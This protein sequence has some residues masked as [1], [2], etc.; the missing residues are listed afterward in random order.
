[1][2]GRRPRPLHPVGVVPASLRSLVSDSQRARLL[3]RLF[4]CRFL[5]GVLVLTFILFRAIT[6]GQLYAPRPSTMHNPK[7]DSE[8]RL[9]LMTLE[10]KKSTFSGN[11]VYAQSIARSL[12]KRGNH[13]LVLSAKPTNKTIKLNN[14]E[15]SKQEMLQETELRMYEIDVEV[16]GSKWGRLDWKS[17]W[18]NFAD[19]ITENVV[20]MVVEFN[21]SWILVVD[22][23]ALP[24]YLRLG[25][26]TGIQQCPMAFLNFRIYYISE[27]KG[28]EGMKEKDFYR[29]ME[30]KAV[31]MASTIAALSSRDAHILSTELGSGISPGV[32]PK[33]LFPPLREDIRSLAMSTLKSSGDWKKGRKYISC[34]VRLSPEKNADL[35]ASIVE[36]L[37]GFMEDQG[38]LPFLC[39]GA[40]GGGEY[41]DSIKQRVRVAFPKAV[42][43]EGFMGP[44]QLADV[45]SQTLLNVHPCIYDA[46]GMT[47]VEAAAF[48]A[49]S[50]VH[51]GLGGAVG[52]AEFLD[53]E[54]GQVFGLDLCAPIEIISSKIKGL[55]IDDLKLTQIGREAGLRSLSWDEDA[56]AGQLLKILESSSGT[57]KSDI[58]IQSLEDYKH[59]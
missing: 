39:G 49:P 17:P 10:Y 31:S 52:A 45:F 28:S 6:T 21:P 54:K 14:G 58:E 32:L 34:C 12:A 20:K 33:P 9:V 44:T 18:R 29:D 25:E 48:E 30:S 27:Y 46:Y 36:S 38:I 23:S 16:E 15:I 35:F 56:N 3:S 47:I 53:P 42:I 40:H 37:A 51:V 1:M 26:A 11:G 22:W 50:I 8:K 43:Y 57:S 24:A 7:L 55:I 41:A 59:K 5:G 13:V 4:F 19:G 2:L